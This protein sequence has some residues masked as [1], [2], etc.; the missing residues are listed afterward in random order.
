[1]DGDFMVDDRIG[2][3][4]REDWYS[5][6]P[7]DKLI[8]HTDHLNKYLDTVPTFTDVYKQSKYK[9][10]PENYIK[11]HLRVSNFKKQLKFPEEG[12]CLLIV[13]HG[14]VVRELSF[15][16]NELPRYQNEIKYCGYVAYRKSNDGEVIIRSRL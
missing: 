5:E 13:T 15:T 1:M 4:L 6:Y 8:Y 2:E 12:T 7:M 14:F 10:F 3:Y 16:M 9:D 11:F